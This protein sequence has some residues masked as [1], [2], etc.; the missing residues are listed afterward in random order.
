MQRAH[1]AAEEDYHVKVVGLTSQSVWMEWDQALKQTLPWKEHWASRGYT[2]YYF[3]L[4]LTV[5]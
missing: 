2:L 3:E 5:Y 4:L 1:E